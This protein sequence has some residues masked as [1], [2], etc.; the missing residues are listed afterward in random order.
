MWCNSE[1]ILYRLWLNKLSG[2]GP[3]A[4]RDLLHEYGSAVNIYNAG[5]KYNKDL[6]ASKRLYE[7]CVRSGI[8]IITFTDPAYPQHAALLTDQPTV[9]F[10]KGLIP[11]NCDECFSSDNMVGVIGPRRCSFEAKQQGIDMSEELC[12]KG[13]LIV[14][15]MAKGID[16][17]AHTAAIKNGNFTIAVLA[18][19]LN[20]CYPVEHRFLKEKIEEHGLLISE[21]EPDQPPLRF[22]FPERNRIIAAW[23]GR[24][25]VIDPGERSGTR[26]TVQFAKNYSREVTI[27]RPAIS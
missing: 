11:G 18:F 13:K 26:S 22:N 8:R 23:S 15:G 4:Q 12:R 16:S 6:D 9:L 1:E 19:G 20:L 5:L 21:Y 24:L 7:R 25:F 14:S 10:T 3:K 17:Y 27:L 2:V